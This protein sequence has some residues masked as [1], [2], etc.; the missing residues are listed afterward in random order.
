MLWPGWCSGIPLIGVVENWANH[1]SPKLNIYPFG[2]YPPIKDH[3]FAGFYYIDSV[4]SIQV[5]CVG[6][7]ASTSVNC[8][9][10]ASWGM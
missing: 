6:G 7:S 1:H 5:C 10:S 8:C 3:C 4:F 2:E 9:S